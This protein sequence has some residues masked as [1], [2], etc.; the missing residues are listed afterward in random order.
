MLESLADAGPTEIL[1]AN[2]TAERAEQLAS[3]AGGRAIR[4]LDLASELSGVDLLLTSTGATS[5]IVDHVG[6][7]NAVEG[8][9]NH[10]L[11]IVDVAVPRDVD[12]L[13]ADLPGVTL[14]DMDDLSAFA[15]AGRRERSMEIAAVDDIISAEVVRFGDLRSAREVA[16]LVISL[17]SQAEAIRQSELDRVSHLLG[18]LTEQQQDAVRSVTQRL[19]AKLL[20]QP[21]ITVKEHVGTPKGDRL[22]D[23]LRDLFDL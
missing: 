13:V 23:S 2:R 22:A 9:G 17:R 20:H 4:L 8:R 14:L 15:A 16:P 11:V 3:R 12:P 7:A 10:P 6:L 18:D 5:I 21:T 1:V 19:V